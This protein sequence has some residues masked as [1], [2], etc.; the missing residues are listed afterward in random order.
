MV[1][2]TKPPL[3]YFDPD[4]MFLPYSVPPGGEIIE[5]N[6]PNPTMQGKSPPLGDEEMEWDPRHSV[7]APFPFMDIAMQL[8][9]MMQPADQFTSPTQ[10][11]PTGQQGPDVVRP[12]MK[13]EEELKQFE[14][15]KGMQPYREERPERLEQLRR[16]APRHMEEERRSAAEMNKRWEQYDKAK[17]NTGDLDHDLLLLEQADMLGPDIGKQAIEDFKTKHGEAKLPKKYQLPDDDDEDAEEVEWEGDK[18]S[19]DLPSAKDYQMLKKHGGDAAYKSFVDRFGFSAL[20]PPAER[21]AV[22]MPRERQPH[23]DENETMGPRLLTVD[24]LLRQGATMSQEQ[25]NEW[26]E[27]R[28]DERATN[29]E[30][31]RDVEM[32]RR[33]GLVE[34]GRNRRRP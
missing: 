34:G 19:P 18:G 32:L 28:K 8:G 9:D 11:P 1:L 24:E 4:E 29:K 20:T 10:R 25:L 5:G 6:P 33:G 13:G 21:P 3:R 23:L 27:G 12:G 22:P 16:D 26:I 17:P 7:L 14:R 2:R 30:I 15:E 31:A